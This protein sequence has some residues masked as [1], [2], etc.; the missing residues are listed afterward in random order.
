M[1]RAGR[2]ALKSGTMDSAPRQQKI[3]PAPLLVV[4]CLGGGWVGHHFYPVHFLPN[5]GV[6][7]PI[8]ATIVCVAALAT[9]SAGVREFHRHGTHTSPFKPTITFVTSGVFRHT[10]NPMYLGLVMLTAGIAVAVNSLAFLLAAILLAAL[11]QLA[12]IKPEER[13]LSARFGKAFETYRSQTRRW[14]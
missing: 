11:L 14:L 13:F 1:S 7:A 2:V 4:F 10:R 12:V 5:L 3:V 9:G 8:L 6:A